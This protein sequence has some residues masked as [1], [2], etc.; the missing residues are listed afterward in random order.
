MSRNEEFRVFDLACKSSLDSLQVALGLESN[1]NKEWIIIVN[2]ENVDRLPQPIITFLNVSFLCRFGDETKNKSKRLL[3]ITHSSALHRLPLS[4]RSSSLKLAYNYKYFTLGE[5][6]E[7]YTNVL[8]NHFDINLDSC[9]V[10]MK[11]NASNNSRIKYEINKDTYNLTGQI[12]FLHSIVSFLQEFFSCSRY[13]AECDHFLSSIFSGSCSLQTSWPDKETG[14]HDI[15]RILPGTWTRGVLSCVSLLAVEMMTCEV[16]LELVGQMS[17][18]RGKINEREL[19]LEP[20]L[21]MLDILIADIITLLNIVYSLF[22]SLLLS[23]HTGA[24]QTVYKQELTIIKQ[25]LEKYLK[26]LK[27]TRE[28]PYHPHH[29]SNLQHILM[30]SG[31]YMPDIHSLTTICSTLVWYKEAL[32]YFKV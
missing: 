19:E 18:K 17:D 21:E 32:E 20:L 24:H 30:L 1:E 2:C 4:L 8:R 31:G 14:T 28:H 9:S 23:F 6:L 12:S 29:P 15:N 7:L 22:K 13:V 11:I 3:V 16:S 27:I 26:L 5:R 10:L 25:K